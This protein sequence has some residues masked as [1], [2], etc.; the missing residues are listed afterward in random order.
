MADGEIEAARLTYAELDRQAREIG[1]ALAG[2]GA[3]GERVVLLFPPGLEFISA[4]FGCLYAGAIAVPAYPPRSR[5]LPRLRAIMEDARPRMVLTTGELLTKAR[6]LLG[7]LADLPPVSW[8]ATESLVERAGEWRQPQIDG[9]TIAFL[10]YTSGSTSTPKGVM[11]SHANLLH[12]EEMIRRAFGQSEE[13]VIL[14]WLPLYHD[15]GLIGNVLQP[16]Y[17]GAPCILMSPI[18]FLQQPLRWLAAISRYRA[19]T[20]GGPNFAYELCV[21]KITEE[22]RA[23][24]DLSSWRVAFNGAEPVRAETLDRFAETFAPCGFHR[25]AFYPCYGLAEATLFAAGGRLEEPSV[26]AAFASAGLEQGRAEPAAGGRNLVGCGGA[27]M[28]QRIEVVDPE[29]ATLC[30]P[31]RSGEIWIAGPSV[32]GGYWG[33]PEATERDFGARL[34]GDPTAGP[35]LRTGDLGF[36]DADGELFVTGRLK[37]LVI[38]RGRNHH[39]QDIE[40]TAERAHP[41]LRP[42]CGAAFSVEIGGEERLI[43]VQ[44]LERSADVAPQEVADAIRSA[45]AQEHEIQVQEIVLT[46]MGTIPKTSSGKIQRYA[47]RAG[48]LAGDLTVVARSEVGAS[49]ELAEVGAEW[50][51]TELTRQALLALEP[52]ERLAVLEPYLRQCAAR[53]L[54]VPPARLEPDQ[55]LTALGLDSLSAVEVKQ[56]VERRLDT[57][58]PLVALLEGATLRSLATELAERL[59]EARVAG[60]VLAAGPPRTELP[61]SHGQKALWFLQRMAPASA[62]YHILGAARIAGQLDVDALRRAFQAL[63]DRHPALRTTYHARAGEPVQ[64][65]HETMAVGFL[66]EK[67]EGLAG[68]E[69]A[70]QLRREAYRPFDLENGP[71]LRVTLMRTAPG[72]HA[73]ALAVH[74]I[75]AD[76]WSLAVLVHELGRLYGRETGEAAEPLATLPLT[77]GDWVRWQ[78]ARLAGD[79]GERL[80]DWWRRA[81]PAP[82][83]D[84]DLPTDRP[85]PAAR[86]DRGA[87]LGLALGSDLSDRIHALA[88][89]S[90]AT[91]FMTLLAGFQ[92]VLHRYTRQEEVA[93]GCPAAGRGA[94]ELAGLVGYFVNPVVVRGDAA[95][96][97]QFG[98]FL[99]RVR[100]WA[101]GAL[102]HQEYPFDLLTKRLQ[103]VRDPS[104]S[105]LFQAMFVLQKSHRP[106]QRALAPFAL[107]TPGA[108]IRLGPLVLSSLSL[109]ERRVQLDLTLEM[110]DGVE[111]LAASL[112]FNADLF[113]AATAERLLVHL[114][115]LLAGAVADPGRTLL[116]LPLL[117]V[118]ETSQILVDW[119]ATA[120]GY[121]AERTLHELFAEQAERTP[122]RVA[123]TAAL[124]SPG[125]SE[126]L[127]YSEL[128]SHARR[129]AHHLAAMGIGPEVPVGVFTDRSSAMVVALLGVLEAGG[130]YVPI[131]PSYPA[132]RVSHML[133]D[134]RA[135]IVLT[136]ERLRPALASYPGRLLCLDSDWPE[137]ARQPETPLGRRAVPDN[138]AYV[139]YTSG[140]TGRPKGVQVSHRGVVNFLTAMARRPGIDADDVMVSVTTLSFDIA[141]LELYLPLIRGARVVLAS[142]ETAADGVALRRL[143][144]DAGATVMQATPATWRL[145][146]AAGW[147]EP[148]IRVLCGGEALPWELADRLHA[149][150]TSVWNL[151]GPTET[152]IWSAVHRLEPETGG[153]AVV[154]IGRPI[155]NTGLYLLDAALRPV[156]VGVAGELLIGGDGLAR[157]YRGRPDLTA[158]KFIPDPVSGVPGARLYRT[159]DLAR[160]RLGG[161]IEFLGRLDHQVKIR[162]FRIEL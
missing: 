87:S 17:V 81:L 161:D 134:S 12:N 148:P 32:A 135:P 162:G 67:A 117:T 99:G 70:A 33:R 119:N 30:P 106:E 39:P 4:F 1:V 141:G 128:A 22:R 85:R 91:L 108:E 122:R 132:D 151:Y 146:L 23:G 8:L 104:R 90:G 130:A 159:G 92:A 143:L 44:E 3:A 37:D 35:F 150:A 27:W 94:P 100:R 139:I 73:L 79:E 83:P 58:V 123:L 68:E 89:S 34:A 74:H 96:D 29:S 157:G 158:E 82:P 116:E 45:V 49:E 36:F 59:S 71:L 88:R 28:E 153:A 126:S 107:G 16:L 155:A 156:P 51:E 147:E 84:L 46:R 86:T 47:C 31:A 2:M 137:I 9:D 154:S 65:V 66:Y 80:W 114:R 131:D 93:V 62:A 52:G 76:F 121:P 136:L 118:G 42:G 43:I 6:A 11:V 129:L 113:D 144:V 120:A 138:L 14:G 57:T 20:S 5:G 110:A 63:V 97:P 125:E 25:E 101:L 78:T 50:G 64:R 140:S 102:E 103:P 112:V 38:L 40:L 55:P 98:T 69:L 48:Y 56:E 15:M 41:A 72:E 18:A 60:P 21:R 149:R 124:L 54:R 145:L 24:L 61:L 13:S 111:G 142:R 53:V 152:T 133:D 75:A 95:G 77:Y 160:F 127:T 26:V 10:Q 19:T 115:S 105:P 109:G 7:G